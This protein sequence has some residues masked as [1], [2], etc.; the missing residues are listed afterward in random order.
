MGGEILGISWQR[1]P[2]HGVLARVV[3][4]QTEMGQM[5]VA[6]Y[7]L[8]KE[9]ERKKKNEIRRKMRKSGRENE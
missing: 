2:F 8:R 7:G 3:V 6:G 5:V 4:G 1:G 9:K